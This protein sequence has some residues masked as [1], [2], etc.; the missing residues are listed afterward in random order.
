MR[1]RETRGLVLMLLPYLFGISVLV[2]LPAIVTFALA[3]Y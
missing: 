2:A 3:L 1:D